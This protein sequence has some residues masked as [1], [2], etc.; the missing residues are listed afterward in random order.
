MSPSEV[1]TP[2][3]PLVRVSLITTF[4]AVDGPLLVVVIV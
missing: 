1:V 4:S 2:V 3:K